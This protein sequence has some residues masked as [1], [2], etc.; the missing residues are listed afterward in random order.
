LI[1][2]SEI[3]IYQNSIILLS[4]ICIDSSDE[5]KNNLIESGIFDV[6]HKK[7]LE[8]SPPPPQ[9]ILSQNYYSVNCIIYG[10]KNILYSNSSCVS[11]FLN[12]PLIPVLLWT[13]NSTL[14]L[15]ITSSDEDIYDI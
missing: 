13:L 2:S 10:I 7:L 15:T 12:T 8:I 9:N 6:Y 14:T 5:E 3:N 4:N 11:S 1:N